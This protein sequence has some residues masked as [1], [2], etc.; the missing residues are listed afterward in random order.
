ME[1]SVHMY[2][3]KCMSLRDENI[4]TYRRE[5]KNI[6]ESV[7][8]FVSAALNC[9]ILLDCYERYTFELTVYFVSEMLF[10]DQ[11][12]KEEEHST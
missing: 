8:N 7:C 11:E 3:C 6:K 4:K 12:K 5:N 1:S 10:F 2:V 9:M